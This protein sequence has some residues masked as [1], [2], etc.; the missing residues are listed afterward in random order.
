MITIQK[1]NKTK[2]KL[3]TIDNYNIISKKLQYVK[4]KNIKMNILYLSYR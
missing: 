1:Y 4:K 3:R 2:I